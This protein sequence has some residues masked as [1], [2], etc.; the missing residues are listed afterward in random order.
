MQSVRGELAFA[1]N[2]QCLLLNVRRSTSNRVALTAIR[3][4]FRYLAFLDYI[5]KTMDYGLLRAGITDPISFLRRPFRAAYSKA[6]PIRASYPH[7][8]S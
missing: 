5:D 2:R 4:N 7:V 1:Y 8:A 6:W 3:G